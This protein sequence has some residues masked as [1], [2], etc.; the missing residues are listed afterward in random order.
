MKSFGY[1]CADASLVMCG[2]T[3]GHVVACSVHGSASHTGGPVQALF[4]R[5]S[6]LCS[7]LTCAVLHVQLWGHNLQHLNTC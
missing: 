2:H 3:S 7:V 4:I 1:F 6:L 5:S